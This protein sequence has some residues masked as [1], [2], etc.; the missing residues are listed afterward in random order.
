MYYNDQP[1][2]YTQHWTIS[3]LDNPLSIYPSSMYME[4][5]ESDFIYPQLCYTN[6]HNQYA[7]Y[8]FTSVDPSVATVSNSGLVTAVGEGSTNIIVYCNASANSCLCIIH[9]SQS[10]ISVSISDTITMEIGESIELTPEV[11]PSNA[12]ASFTWH[13]S[14]NSV[15]TVSSEGIVTGVGYGTAVVNCT[16]QNGITSNDCVVNVNYRMPQGID[17]REDT[18]ILLLGDTYQL[19]CNVFPSGAAPNV[20]WSSCD[21]YI[22]PINSNGLIAGFHLCSAAVIATTVNGLQDTCIVE[23]RQSADSVCIRD[24]VSL[25]VGAQYR[26]APSF[27]PANGYANDLQWE[28]DDESIVSVEDGIITG[29]GLGSTIVRV[30]NGQGLYAESSVYVKEMNQVNV[31]LNSGIKYSYPI[32]YEPKITYSAE[33]FVYIEAWY[34]TA[35]YDLAEVNKITIAD[36]AEPWP[37]IPEPTAV[38][39]NEQTPADLFISNGQ[40]HVSKIMPKASVNVYNIEGKLLRSEK[41]NLDGSLTISTDSF[42]PG[43]YII[44]TNNKSFKIIVP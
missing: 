22:V 12:S 24:H 18:C 37:E 44:Q 38:M 28:S 14:D 11:Y 7:T 35:T 23:V 16:T 26:Y 31:W 3:C 41:A 33:G 42:T 29:V 8:T 40:I 15:A 30:F 2:T 21:E 6:N 34:L 20:S 4:P 13:S 5:G 43:L 32:E 27:V 25:A 10:P 19:S 17:I 9:I 39:E 36:D 1:Q